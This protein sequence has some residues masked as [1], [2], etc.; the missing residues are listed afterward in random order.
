VNPAQK[1]LWN[2]LLD[3]WSRE[4]P[5]CQ[6][7]LAEAYTQKF[8]SDPFGW[9][10]LA[11]GLTQISSFKKATIALCTALRLASPEHRHV[12]YSKSGAYYREK[13]DL[14]R[15]ERWYRKAIANTESQEYLVFLGACLAKQGRYAESRYYHEK[16][17]DIDPQKADEALFNLG[18]LCRAESN[19][20]EALRFFEKAIEIDPD[21]ADA[22]VARDDILQLLKIRSAKAANKF[23]KKRV[24][25]I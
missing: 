1:Q 4:T 19:F 24:S 20:V 14:A 22:R 10:I 3:A 23:K 15:A 5:A 2:E 12:V 6:I 18:L 17:I 8:P 16:A 7:Y 11:D 21:Y 13:G 9:I 25:D